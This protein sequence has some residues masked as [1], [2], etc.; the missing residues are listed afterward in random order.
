[1]F[2]NHLR[3]H[4]VRILSLSLL[5]LF[6][7]A[8]SPKQIFSTEHLSADTVGRS[9]HQNRDYRE[10]EDY[11]RD[12]GP[13]PYIDECDILDEKSIDLI[14]DVNRAFEKTG[15]QIAV[16]VVP[17]LE[18]QTIEEAANEC[19]RTLGVGDA[20][21]HNG[22][23]LYVALNDRK[24]RIEVGY[25]AEGFATDSKCGRIIR[26]VIA[27][28]FKAGDYNLGI[29]KGIYALAHLVSKEYEIAL[30]TDSERYE[31]TESVSKTV[32]QETSLLSKILAFLIVLSPI[33]LIIH[34]II[35]RRRDRKLGIVRPS[36]FFSSDS[37]SSSSSYS[38]SSSSS[39]SSSSSDF[40]GFGGG[41][42]GG[43]GASGGW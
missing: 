25:G 36:R 32:D 12:L 10:S 8:I 40:S 21:K 28:D 23:L 6:C 43:G 31:F 15:A 17:S 22:L 2:N 33:G 7:V 20:T 30:D 39:R 16:V 27:P 11:D 37:S 38:S 5:L 13:K 4:Y 42:S 29:Q 41:S 18:D 24:M 9:S 1:M 3:R 14:Y 34:R 26:D 35:R 19:F